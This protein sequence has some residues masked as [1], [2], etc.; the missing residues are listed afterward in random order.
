MANF[1]PP[2]KHSVKRK[3]SQPDR[4]RY[5]LHHNF[6]SSVVTINFQD[7]DKMVRVD[8]AT[9]RLE[10]IPAKLSGVLK[11]AEIVVAVASG[12]ANPSPGIDIVRKD[13]RDAPF[14]FNTDHYIVVEK[15][16]QHPDYLS[17]V[18]RAGV[19]DSEDLRSALESWVWIIGPKRDPEIH[20]S[21]E[22][23]EYIHNAKEKT[24]PSGPR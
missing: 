19:Q 4:L 3:M 11:S 18:R 14:I 16:T 8:G 10:R 5:F 7:W 12:I 23:P 15:L 22:I 6:K 20:W 1:S 17:F 13:P 9:T 21:K 2:A 24:E